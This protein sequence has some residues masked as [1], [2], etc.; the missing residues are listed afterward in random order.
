[1]KINKTEIIEKAVKMANK[2]KFKLRKNSPEILVVLGIIGAVG[3]TILACSATTKLEDVVDE[4]KDELNQIHEKEAD[5]AID[6]PENEKR[7]DVVRTYAK[8]SLKVAGLYSP[9]VIV[10]ALSITSIL[11]SHG[12]VRK[13][14]AALAAAYTT[15]YQEFKKYRSN[16]V[17]AYGE[18]VDTKLRHG[19][20]TIKVDDVK[21]DPETGKKKKTKKAVDV[22]DEDKANDYTYQ[23]DSRSS[24]FQDVYDYNMMFLRSQQAYLTNVLQSRGYLFLNDVLHALGLPKDKRGQV[25]G[26]IFDE[27]DPTKD[28]CVDFRICETNVRDEDGELNPV[29]LLDFNVDGYILDDADYGRD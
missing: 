14:N 19:I 15:V 11:A 29:I 5:E 2:T 27:T 12:I 25:V 8:T 6:Y 23:F 26:W 22:I 3:S 28:N 21:V 20:E 1:M 16:V 4:G 9:A 7:K 24:Q 10:G 17:S 18:D 13:R